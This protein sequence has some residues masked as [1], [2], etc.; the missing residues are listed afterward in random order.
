M[1]ILSEV[2]KVTLDINDEFWPQYL[3][4]TSFI[5]CLK[6]HSLHSKDDNQGEIW[7][8]F[9][10]HPLSSSLSLLRWH[11]LAS[12]LSRSFSV[13]FSIYQ[14]WKWWKEMVM[15]LPKV[16]AKSTPSFPLKISSEN[17]Q[18]K[19]LLSFLCSPVLN[20]ETMPLMYSTQMVKPYKVR[21]VEV[22]LLLFN[23]VVGQTKH[24]WLAALSGEIVIWSLTGTAEVLSQF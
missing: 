13:V 8:A 10:R 7:T 20:S 22:F 3:M 6:F 5:M 2:Q 1:I 14:W 12:K 11:L 4:C 16:N 23:I 19:P 24:W 15:C 21:F 18:T 17:C 9:R